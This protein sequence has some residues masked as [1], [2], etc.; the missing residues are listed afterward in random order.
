MAFKPANSIQ[1]LQYFGEFGGVNPSIS[2]S[3]TYTFLSAKTMF[4][5]FEGNADGCYLYSRHSS[6]S[7][8]YL[9]EALAAMEGTETAN[10]AA[11]GMGAITPVLMQLCSAGDHIVSSRTIYGGTYA[12]LK[13]FTPKFNIQTSFVDITKLDVVEAAITKNTKVLYCE[14]VSNPLL[15]VAD[16]KGLAEIAKRHNLKLVVDNTFSPLSISPA[17]L[18]ADIVI[19]SLTKFI[20]GSSDTVG[21]V[22]CGTQ[23]FINDLRNV[24]DGAS[25]L[26][27]STMDSFRSA[28][29]LKNLRTLHIRMQQHSFNATYLAEKF[30][31]SG[32]KTVYPGL[33][34]HPSHNLFKS[35]MNEKY[36]FGGMLTID[37]A[38]LDKANELMEMMQ[39]KNLGYLAVSL[40]FYKTLFSAPGSSTSSEIPEEEQLEMGLSDGLI[41]FSIGLDAD[42][43]RTYQ[44]MRDCMVN[45]N[46]LKE[47]AVIK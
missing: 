23:E 41:R 33:A 39:E 32:L 22:V 15:E 19:H 12:F 11:S 37:V 28:S 29:I 27:G 34:S 43:E 2:D 6:P 10:V 17:K 9:G 44:M 47:E 5:T 35:M 16:I 40:G 14:S 42:I 8:L 45:L 21:G 1:D 20:N 36:G 31:A 24:N 30:E 13:N 4:D 3:S 38:T 18:G 25:M 7:N 26:L 46:I